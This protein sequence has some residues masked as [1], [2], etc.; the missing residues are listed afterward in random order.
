[1]NAYVIVETLQDFNSIVTQVQFLQTL[2][3]IETLQFDDTI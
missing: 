2:E 3:V 1:M